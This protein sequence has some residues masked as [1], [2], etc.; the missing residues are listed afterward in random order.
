MYVFVIKI[1]I[2]CFTGVI[3]KKPK[4]LYL[5][6]G[7]APTSPPSAIITPMVFFVAV[8]KLQAKGKFV[9]ICLHGAVVIK[10]DINA[11]DCVVGIYKRSWYPIHENR[12]LWTDEIR[13][14]AFKKK[15]AQETVVP[16]PRQ[17]NC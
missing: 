6:V 15:K 13:E 12:A 1:L 16:H 7:S 4:E 3:L 8:K 17:T 2:S 5:L 10:Q 11:I 9:Q 14:P